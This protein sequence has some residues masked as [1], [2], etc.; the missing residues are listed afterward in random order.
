MKTRIRK[1][2]WVLLALQLF[3]FI[4]PYTLPT[5]VE[6]AGTTLVTSQPVDIT[7]ASQYQSTESIAWWGIDAHGKTEGSV[8]DWNLKVNGVNLGKNGYYD[9]NTDKIVLTDIPGKKVTFVTRK[10]TDPGHIVWRQLNGKTWQH[11]FG[12]S[13]KYS[14]EGEGFNSA[15][16]SDYPGYIDNTFNMTRN[17][18][19]A[20]PSSLSEN[21]NAVSRPLDVEAPT[22]WYREDQACTPKGECG[23]YDQG[24]IAYNNQI[25][26]STIKITQ[27]IAK[28]SNKF[29][30]T[31]SACP[32][33]E[34]M[35]EEGKGAL[36]VSKMLMEG[37]NKAG[38]IY[39]RLD[40]SSGNVEGRNYLMSAFA[41]WSGESYEYT[42]TITITYKKPDPVKPDLAPVNLVPS[43]DPIMAED[44]ITF[45]ASFKNI[46]VATSGKFYVTMYKTDGS[47]PLKKA[48]PYD[49]IG[50]GKTEEFTF[51]YIF[52]SYSESF[53]MR[54]NSDPDVKIDEQ[55]YENNDQT[56]KFIPKTGGLDSITADFDILPSPSL[57]WRD[58]FT[59]RPKNINT[60]SCVYKGHDYKLVNGF[61]SYSPVAT[62]KTQ[63]STFNY[64]TY[65][66]SIAPGANDI[67]IRVKTSCGDSDWMANKTL[68]LEPPRDN[69]PP[70][71]KLAWMRPYDHTRGVNQVLVG[72]ILDVG[73]IEDPKVPTPRDPDGDSYQFVGFD[74]TNSD[75]WTRDLYNEYK[76]CCMYVDGFHGIRM[77][78]LG[79]HVIS[80]VMRDQWGAT[81]TST[82]AISVVPPN[83]VPVISGST[84]VVEGRPLK[85]PL[86]ADLSFSPMGRSINHSLDAWTNKANSYATP[87]VQT[88]TLRV[89]DSDGLASIDTATHTISV[90]PD[91]PPIPEIEYNSLS[92][93][94]LPVDFRN[95]TSS[96]DGDQIVV[97]TVKY[98]YDSNNNGQY[99]D[100]TAYSLT[101]NPDRTIS[102]VPTKVGNYQI[103]VYAKEDWGKEATKYF[104][105][106]VINDAPS[107]S[108]ETSS[109]AV[110]PS[111][112]PSYSLSGS[113]LANNPAWL[114]TNAMAT[115]IRK[116]WQYNGD[117][118]ISTKA[119]K[120]FDP[121][122]GVDTNTR[123]PIP[124]PNGPS[125]QTGWTTDYAALYL[126][127]AG[128]WLYTTPY[129]GS[130]V[131]GRTW[132][133]G[134]IWN[135]S[136]GAIGTFKG[137]DESK[138]ELYTY[139]QN[140]ESVD[141]LTLYNHYTYRLSSFLS[142][143]LVELSQSGWISS[144]SNPMNSIFN[145]LK[146]V[147]YTID[148]QGS[149]IQA[150]NPVYGAPTTRVVK[151]N[152]GGAVIWDTTI[153]SNTCSYYNGDTD[154]DGNTIGWTTGYGTV[155]PLTFNMDESLAVVAFQCGTNTSTIYI[156]NSF[157]GSIVGTKS[158]SHSVSPG[159]V[160]V[161]GSYFGKIALAYSFDPW[162]TD[163]GLFVLDNNFNEVFH[164]YESGYW[165]SA[166]L[167]PT[168]VTN[169]GYV[170]QGYP[171]YGGKTRTYLDLATLTYVFN[172]YTDS[173][174]G[175][176]VTGTALS[177]DSSCLQYEWHDPHGTGEYEEVCVKPWS[178]YFISPPKYGEKLDSQ[179]QL[180]NPAI[181]IQNSSIN[182]KLK[183]TQNVF[184][185]S[186]F[187]YFVSD[188]VNMY[189]VYI[190]D[191][192]VQLVK[193]VGGAE[194]E[195]GRANYF[196][197]ANTYYSFKIKTVDGN[198]IV[199]VNGIPLINVNDYTFSSGSLGPMTE[200][201]G[202]YFKDM[203]YTDL[204][205]ST[206]TGITNKNTAIVSSPV[207]N[208]I[209]YQDPELDPSIEPLSTWKYEQIAHNFLNAGDG[210]YGTSVLHGNTYTSPA[211]SFDK[212]G[213]YKISFTAKD[214]P[215]P[216]YLYPSMVFNAQRLASNTYSRNIIIH[217]KPVSQFTVS[218]AGDGTIVWND[219]SYDPDRWLSAGNY[220]TEAI[221]INYQ[222]TRGILDRKYYYITPSGITVNGQL[223]RPTESGVYTVGL[224]V[225]DEYR[226]WSDFVTQDIGST[227]VTPPN[228]PPVATLTYPTGTQAAPTIVTMQNPTIT[229]NQSDV[230]G[231][232]IQK[233]EVQ[234][235]NEG[236]TVVSTSGQA[237]QWNNVT[238]WTSSGLSFGSKYKARVRVHD[239]YQWS[240]WSNEQWLY[241]NSPPVA[242]WIT[243][244]TST[245]VSPYLYGT[246]RPTFK[247]SQTD[248]D[249]NTVFTAYWIHVYN[250]SGGLVYDSGSRGQNTRLNEQSFT[251]P[252][253]LPGNR[254]YRLTV[255]VSDGY[256]WS[257]PVSSTFVI[258]QKPVA[259]LLDIPPS[260]ELRPTIKWNQTDPDP[261]TTF[262][263]YQIW[264]EDDT[265]VVIWT[266]TETSQNTTS[267]TNQLKLPFD[268][269]ENKT[270]KAYMIVKDE[271]EYSLQSNTIFI[272]TIIN[273]K[274]V[275]ATLYPSGDQADPTIVTTMQ[276]TLIFEQTDD[277]GTTFTGLRVMGYNES[278]AIV[279]D[280]GDRVQN[281]RESGVTLPLT[282]ALPIGTKIKIVA[283]T[284]DESEWS[285]WSAEKWIYVNTPPAAAVTNPN[286]TQAAPTIV[287]TDMPLI[288]FSQS[289]ADPGTIYSH[290]RVQILDELNTLIADSGEIVQNTTATTN[291]W[292]TNAALPANKK[293]KVRVQVKDGYSWSNWSAYTWLFFNTPPAATVYDP[294]GNQLVPTIIVNNLR[295]RIR[296]YQTDADPGTLFKAYEV[297][298]Y[299]TSG[300]ALTSGQQ[301]QNTVATSQEWTP[302]TNLAYNTDYKV[303]T[304]VSDGYTWSDWSD[305]Q[306]FRL[307]PNTRPTA[308]VTYPSGTQATP[309]IFLVDQPT[310]VWDQ[311][312][313]DY[314]TSFKWFHIRI[315]SEDNVLV[316][317]FGVQPQDTQETV[318]TWKVT[319]NLD[320]GKKLKVQVRVS[321]GIDWSDW[322]TVKWMLGNRP[323]L[324]AFDWSPKPVWEGDV[325]TL[326]NQSS[327]PDGDALTYAWEVRNPDGSV[328]FTSSAIQPTQRFV[329]LGTYSVKLTVS[330]A[331]DSRSV[332]GAIQVGELTI[333]A[334][335]DHTPQW[336][337]FHMERG[338][339]TTII[340]LDFYSGERFQLTVTTSPT[341]VDRV[342][343]TLSTTGLD[344]NDL[345]VAAGLQRQGTTWTFTGELFDSRFLSL[346]E[347][348]PEGVLPIHFEV[349]YANG[350]V[351]TKEVPVR[352]IGNVQELVTVHRQQ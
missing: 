128:Q 207:V 187:A 190:T 155:T 132:L 55:S 106:S 230:N 38:S 314:G 311:H 146:D 174:F 326:L 108:F 185:R 271:R 256:A 107:V 63:D 27:A 195:I 58:S 309:T 35:T 147:D 45:T 337:E 24:D 352:I 241:V 216:N 79:Y 82:A 105:L 118:S 130:R 121:F 191:K 315:V 201:V 43:K 151:K 48:G 75:T 68:D 22:K 80:G 112:A 71:F 28:E 305:Y 307:K 10:L 243:P 54:V 3:T 339:N 184:L 264:L 224:A 332:T 100:E 164:H 252:S 69:S 169:N 329:L 215:H 299:T 150:V 8:V 114:S 285:D 127:R 306:W 278:G 297:E 300:I 223:T 302:G 287:N 115:N 196:F 213:T 274:P 70:D 5:S 1:L 283:K 138:D 66:I 324:A 267:A 19:E 17:K 248:S 92:V 125:Y 37:S 338:H 25:K 266:S 14:F 167:I 253:D 67:S 134:Q 221:G 289:D 272:Q 31:A 214:D 206:G 96:P 328:L 237:A 205:A 166:S 208:S 23:E 84:Q 148:S 296:W 170:L 209:S 110:E 36:K 133:F 89:T 7:F 321:D 325:V 198:H 229:W 247:W 50:A 60:G 74:V 200:G 139:L 189:R 250:E 277:S 153:P 334:M 120:G 160:K 313:D 93:R 244:N 94:N 159:N 97:N 109:T 308:E 192:F 197:S 32:Y 292:F 11:Q 59:L 246:T 42:G 242:A 99:W 143:S 175:N 347:G 251:M 113:D 137:V 333:Q 204:G 21:G 345:D 119:Y 6:A 349:R 18:A 320:R 220:S 30:T 331:V 163:F 123:T 219:T 233:Y 53:T 227:I 47:V 343:A 111:V 281:T 231:D 330:D 340:P 211:T 235:I 87:G 288:T 258:N 222:S 294:G 286:G 186:G 126:P 145:D 2:S 254:K 301:A 239:G 210:K 284:K 102:F 341:S 156:F 57:K 179:T 103:E 15:G 202:V 129:Y 232:V 291:Q 183:T 76:T 217:R 273:H 280:T 13:D 122:T 269:G 51:T 212:V 168:H 298:I 162:Q 88:V 234:L 41:I 228:A 144:N 327:D 236:G 188:A 240:P 260:S 318:N 335:V 56:W 171:V 140:K 61:A 9:P 90:T 117:G 33:P 203:G 270:Y 104:S 180:Y 40:G 124:H 65:P 12:S 64:S 351:K 135:Q 255:E 312:D 136:L 62:S 344:G 336:L 20:E 29:N 317:D 177:S 52:G 323:P 261:G 116:N 282:T 304:R 279:L 316:Y 350:V 348:L 245:F 319:Q 303:R 91:L 49:G 262:T 173:T 152:S 149:R 72:T 257:T 142:G 268:L 77:D 26:S 172:S 263:T 98:R 346:T 276:P 158:L 83:P 101:I 218:Q 226:A 4:S 181:T 85:V 78:T 81:S 194:T 342:T 238:A 73:Y 46:G 157:T 290:F 322:S 39:D 225:M 165:S 16:L 161:L 295:P 293:L 178:A 310:I 154:G 141:N 95:K 259:T 182:F 44:S 34:C 249:V 265:N 176:A 86:N 131:S 193:V 275:I 199:Y